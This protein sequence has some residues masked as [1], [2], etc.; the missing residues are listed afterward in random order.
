MLALDEL[1][2]PPLSLAVG[3]ELRVGTFTAP[4]RAQ[5]TNLGEG[6]TDLGAFLSAGRSGG[7]NVSETSGPDSPSQTRAISGASNATPLAKSAHLSSSTS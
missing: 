4:E 6:T 3:G 1:Y 5:L 2:G 7:G